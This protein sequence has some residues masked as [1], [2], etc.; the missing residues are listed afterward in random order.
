MVSLET[1]N[2]TVLNC[3]VVDDSKTERLL[4]EKFIKN[5]DGLKLLTQYKCTLEAKNGLN[6]QE[7][8]LI[9]L[10]IDMPILS[11][12]ELLDELK[13]KP[14]VIFL[15]SETEYAFKAFDYGA[16]DYLQKPIAI[17]RFDFAIK[18]AL[19]QYKLRIDTSE[20]DDKHIYVKSNLKKQKVYIK[21]IKWIQALG[22]YIQLVTEEKNLVVLSTMKSFEKKLPEGKFFRIHKSYIVSLEKIVRFNSKNVE[23]GTYEIPLSRNKKTQLVD[24]LNSM[25]L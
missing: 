24:A 15:S 9:F 22:D 19:N 13:I 14:Q 2:S 18:K 7:I 17:E 12:F 6:N 8:D 16:T 25:S 1:K 20:T 5:H 4:L 10:N 3:V 23:I 11:G 21:D